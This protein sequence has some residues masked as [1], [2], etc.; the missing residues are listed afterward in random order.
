MHKNRLRKIAL[1]TALSTT[2][3]T[4]CRDNKKDDIAVNTPVITTK[5]E[6]NADKYQ[7]ENI[8]VVSNQTIAQIYEE[9]KELS[10]KDIDITHLRIEEYKEPKYIWK[11]GDKYI[12]DYG[13]NG[14]DNEEYTYIDPG[15]HGKMYAVIVKNNDIVSEYEPIAAL[16]NIDGE[17]FNVKVTF[18][19]DN[20]R[21]E[22][23]ENYI[24]IDNPTKE[25]FNNIKNAEEYI[26]SD[27]KEAAITK[28]VNNPIL[29]QL[30]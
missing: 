13:I 2:L 3:L 8:D 11:K 12:Y 25:D 28:E 5:I 7:D 17:V 21:Y 30:K 20:T 10:N 4:G 19:K 23:S 18:Y 26:Y 1:L 9:Y 22:P 15:Y 16:A 24:T 6:E 29:L 14:Y 27:N